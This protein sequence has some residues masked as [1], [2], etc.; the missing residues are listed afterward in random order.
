MTLILA[1]PTAAGIVMASDTQYTS[2]EVRCSGPK[3]YTLNP[4]CAWAG[5]GEIALIQR[6]QE[7]IRDISARHGL[8]EVRDTLAHVVRQAVHALLELDVLTEFVQNEPSMM[9]ALHPGDFVFAEY[10]DE[11]PRMLHIAA[12]GTPEWIPGFFA[13][14]NGAN[15]AYALLQK[16]QDIPLS[17]ENAAL[18]AYRVIDESIQVGAFGLDYPIDVWLI[19]PKGIGRLDA[20]ELKQLATASET[21]RGKEI[22]LLQQVPLHFKPLRPKQKAVK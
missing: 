18:L 2:G 19:G 17:L 5:A 11:T 14:G 3:I 21:L 16:Y 8:A 6:V 9:L 12:N 10:R 22:H 13:S 4:N 20:D 7:D 15:F 1:L